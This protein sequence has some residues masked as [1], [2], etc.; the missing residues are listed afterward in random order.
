LRKYTELLGRIEDGLESA[1]FVGK[2]EHYQVERTWVLSPLEWAVEWHQRR[3][4]DN[5]TPH[6]FLKWKLNLWRRGGL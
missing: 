3:D 5:E 6:Y 1:H 2:S 4:F